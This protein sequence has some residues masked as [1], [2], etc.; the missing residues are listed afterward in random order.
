MTG[1]GR[2]EHPQSMKTLK[3]KKKIVI[4]KRPTMIE[5]VIE[6]VGDQLTHA[7]QLFRMS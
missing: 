7:L 2:P 4:E 6:D 5:V 3:R 1:D